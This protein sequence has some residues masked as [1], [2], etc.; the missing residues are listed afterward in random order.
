MVNTPT[1]GTRSAIKTGS[2]EGMGTQPGVLDYSQHVGIPF[3]AYTPEEMVTTVRTWAEHTWPISPQEAFPLR[4]QRHWTPAPD[5]DTFFATPVSNGETDG[6]IMKDTR[7][8]H[9]IRSTDARMTTRAP[10][11]LEPHVSA[12]V[13]SICTSYRDALSTILRTPQGELRQ[14]RSFQRLGTTQQHVSK[15]RTRRHICENRH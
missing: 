1:T 8:N 12:T 7:D 3:Y 6:T 14:K 10:I 9:L 13:K 15:P 2:G 4:D 5:D 11:K